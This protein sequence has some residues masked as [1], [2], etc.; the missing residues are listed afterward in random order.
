[1]YLYAQ[2]SPII[3]SLLYI[4]LCCIVAYSIVFTLLYSIWSLVLY[5]IV[6][7]CFVRYCIVCIHIL[8]FVFNLVLAYN[9]KNMYYIIVSGVVL[10]C[11]VLYCNGMWYGMGLYC[12]VLSYSSVLNIIVSYIIL[13]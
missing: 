9:I 3:P 12:I 13:S 4:R 7:Y 6:W 10:Y 5:G 2:S 8:C 11:T 1:M